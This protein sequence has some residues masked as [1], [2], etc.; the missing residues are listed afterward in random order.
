MVLERTLSRAGYEVRTAHSGEEAEQVSEAFQPGVILLD[1]VMPGRDGMATCRALKNNP[2]TRSIPVIFVTTESP[3]HRIEDAF[4]AGGADYVT[5]PYHIDE[6]LARV[7]VQLKLRQAERDLIEK[8]MFNENLARELQKTNEQLAQQARLDPLTALL[9]R[10]AWEEAAEREF[11]IARRNK[12]SLAILMIDVDYFKMFNDS[13]G[14]PAGD[15]CLRK[16][17]QLLKDVC[18][19]SDLIGRYGGEEFVVLTPDADVKGAINLAE[20]VRVGISKKGVPHPSSPISTWV[21][22]SV[23]VSVRAECSLPQSLHDADRALYGAKRNGRNCIWISENTQRQLDIPVRENRQIATPPPADVN[24]NQHALLIAVADHDRRRSLSHLAQ[25]MGYRVREALDGP[26]ALA[27][28]QSTMPD[29]AVL[30][31]DL[32]KL[33]GLECTKTLRGEFTTKDVPII[34]I[35]GDDETFG[36]AACLEAGTDECIS[37]PINEEEFGLRL[38]SMCR[39]ADRQ[40]ALIQSYR[41]RGEQSRILSVLLDFC[42]TLTM[43]G[44]IEPIANAIIRATIEI[45]AARTIGILLADDNGRTLRIARSTGTRNDEQDGKPIPT[46][47]GYCGAVLAAGA[48]LSA[49]ELEE[50][51]A[52]MGELEAA[53]WGKS[54]VIGIPL[55]TGD[56]A[57]GVLTIGDLCGTDELSGLELESLELVAVVGGSALQGYLSI[58]ARDQARDAIITALASLAERRDADTG[59][60]IERVTQYS[61]VLAESLRNRPGFAAE[62][63]DT[64][65]HHLKRAVP[66]HDIGKVAIPDRI[67][68][69]PGKLTDDEVRVMRTHAAIGAQTISSIAEN[70]P[71]ASFLSM[72]EHIA[73][74]HHHWFDGSCNPDDIKGTD[75]PLSARLVAV[76][77]VYDALT[78]RRCYKEAFTHQKALGIIE[79]LKDSQFDPDV[80]GAFVENADTFARLAV[81]LE[82][83]VVSLCP[84]E[85]DA[86]TI[87]EF[88]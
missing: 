41:M 87:G 21:T 4:A 14:H 53:V 35:R 29:V 17:A 54:P 77:D 70:T 83:D 84:Q 26:T 34:L 31:A 60:H 69:K 3:T 40:R 38:R 11:K 56:G 71:G 15:D 33:N 65:M 63:D 64:F 20:R 12:R 66:L 48:R 16:V 79:K 68:N 18:R 22:V 2:R 30:D 10:R 46:D 82:D 36:I 88:I 45:T 76:S 39:L 43:E 74:Y 85:Y 7:S 58:Q 19:T 37:N 86:L 52:C 27:E 78:S 6:I 72:A 9:N 62:I 5:K 67:L 55:G 47:S 57:V 32:P 59:L 24:R 25:D 13:Q 61:L 81:E 28:I 80:V 8:T 23:G 51:G 44:D 1:M 75:I 49:N 50:Y 42:R 73:R